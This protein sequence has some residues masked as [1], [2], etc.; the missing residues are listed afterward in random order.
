MI[1]CLGKH[2]GPVS[3]YLH[4]GLANSKSDGRNSLEGSYNAA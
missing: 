1:G 3:S 2:C 4:M